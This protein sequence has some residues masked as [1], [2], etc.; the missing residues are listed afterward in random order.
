MESEK[1]QQKA[2]FHLQFSIL[3]MKLFQTELKHLRRKGHG[4]SMK[5]ILS[6]EEE[7]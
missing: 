1:D 3:L 5:N 4:S 2:Q 7:K 6:E